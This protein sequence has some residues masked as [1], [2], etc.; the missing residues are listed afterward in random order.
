VKE[1]GARD[2]DETIVVAPDDQGRCRQVANQVF[3]RQRLGD[4]VVEYL[5]VERTVH[6]GLLGEISRD[7]ARDLRAL[8]EDEVE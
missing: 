6:D 8:D 1:V 4:Q 5:F 7:R 3:E 2:V